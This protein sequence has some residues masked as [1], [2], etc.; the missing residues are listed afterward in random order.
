MCSCQTVQRLN[1]LTVMLMLMLMLAVLMKVLMS[2][3]CMSLK[4]KI[5][6]RNPR[7]LT[8]VPSSSLSMVFPLLTYLLTTVTAV[9][10][11]DVV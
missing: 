2:A 4:A 3:A 1:K 6:L 10:V 7:Q 5:T 8:A 9:L 11:V